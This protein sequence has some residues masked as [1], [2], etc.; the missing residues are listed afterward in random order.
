MEL[1]HARRCIQEMM[2]KLKERE[3]HALLEQLC[4]R[5]TKAL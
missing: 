2:Q 4:N 1:D 3:G 5:F